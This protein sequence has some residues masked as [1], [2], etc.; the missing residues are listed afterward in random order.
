MNRPGDASGMPPRSVLIVDDEEDIRDSFQQ[1]L[2][3][4]LDGARV[5]V[6]EDG[7]TALAMMEQD[8]PDLIISDY[9]M[10]GMN[11]LEF[12]TEAQRRFGKIPCI[13]LTAGREGILAMEAADLEGVERL[14][15]KPPDM[16]KFLHEV[17]RILS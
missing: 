4:E 17:H 3:M 14:F 1:V 7:P 11:G 5:R 16:M 2:D 13:V 9:F 8:R 6:A 10:P 12:L 15:D